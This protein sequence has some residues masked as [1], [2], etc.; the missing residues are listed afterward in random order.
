MRLILLVSVSFLALSGGA[1]AQGGCS[2]APV[3]AKLADAAVVAFKANPQA[4]IANHASAGLPLSTEARSLLL[5]DPTLIDALLDAAKGGNDVQK[6][7]IGA[8]LAEAS[9]VLVC[10]NPQLAATIQQKIAQSNIGP[11][12]TAY[13]AASNGTETA[14]IGGGGGGGGGTGPVGGVGSNPGSNT[15]SNPNSGSYFTGNGVTEAAL[16]F[17]GGGFSQT[18]NNAVS[19][20]SP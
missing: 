12:I 11:L 13:I 14:A 5:T 16:A 9:K 7:A 10:S 18:A 8:G 4:I 17:S 2:A 3:F 1:Y 20:T 15:G 6:A 19:P